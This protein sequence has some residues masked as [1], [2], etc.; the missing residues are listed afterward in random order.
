MN[1]SPDK[2]YWWWFWVYLIRACGLPFHLSPCK[3]PQDEARKLH[4]VA[5]HY[6]VVII[7]NPGGWGDSALC[8]ATDFAPILNGIQDTLDRLGYQSIVVPYSRVVPGWLGKIAATKEQLN[9]FKHAS[10]IQTRDIEQLSKNFPQKKFLIAG[11]SVGGGLSGK[12]L[13]NIADLANVYGITVGV[14]GWYRTHSSEKSLVLNNSNQD[15]ISV[16]NVRTVA[17]H[18]FRCPAR[19]LRSRLTDRRLSLALAMQFPYHDY[20]WSSPEVGLPITK[21]LETHF[22]SKRPA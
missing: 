22:Q 5:T 17:I 16:G 19:W 7:F 8:D 9:S 10:E 18:V 3:L 21:F 2:H 20:P 1:S 15:P 4:Q 13:K 11:F 14:P 6:D 12:T